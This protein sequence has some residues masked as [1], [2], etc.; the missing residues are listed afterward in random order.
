MRS[1]RAAR[2]SAT[3]RLFGRGL[4]PAAAGGTLFRSDALADDQVVA[5]LET[6]S[7]L[8]M[9]QAPAPMDELDRLFTGGPDA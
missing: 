6:L 7:R 1:A 3:L 9:R 8:A 2:H 4:R 5:D